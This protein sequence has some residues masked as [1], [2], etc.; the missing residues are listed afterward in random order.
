MTPKAIGQWNGDAAMRI[1]HAKLYAQFTLGMATNLAAHFWLFYLLSGDDDDKP[2]IVWSP[3]STDFLKLKIGETRLDYL[4]G[5]QQ[6]I[7][8]AT[9]AMRGKSMNAK[10]EVYSLYNAGDGDKP[11]H[12]SADVVIQ[13]GRGKLGPGPSGVLDWIA[14]QNLIGEPKTKTDIVLE[15]IQPITYP[16]LWEAEKELGMKRGTITALDGFFGAGVNTYG[17]RTTYRNASEAERLEL[18]EKDLENLQWDDPPEPAYAEFLTEDQLQAFRDR[19]LERR[20]DVM[21]AATYD[22]ENEKTLKTRDKNIGFLREMK[23]EGVSLAE[24]ERL[25]EAHYR[26]DDPGTK[27]DESKFTAGERPGFKAKREV[28]RTIYGE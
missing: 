3:L 17:P 4:G 21:I 12:D 15:R 20:S 22:G 25:L 14:G 27:K 28:L 23:A 10:G 24:A 5:M 6:P 26:Q 2:E 7:V 9:R 8:M 13:W 11:W 18:V 19:R 1:A 16:E